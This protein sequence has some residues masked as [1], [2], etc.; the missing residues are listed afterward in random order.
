LLCREEGTKRRIE[1]RGNLKGVGDKHSSTKRHT[2]QN[3]DL[4]F[5][6]LKKNENSCK[7]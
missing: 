5:G 3:Y 1:E 4:D 7:L 6:E 2:T